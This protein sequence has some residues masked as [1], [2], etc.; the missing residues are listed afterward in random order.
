M[1]KRALALLAALPLAAGMA[2]AV[3]P[4]AHAATPVINGSVI[5]AGNGA[6]Y[7]LTNDQHTRY[8]DAQEVVKAVPGTGVVLGSVTLY[9]Q[10]STTSAQI[11]LVAVTPGVYAVK[12]GLGTAF[13]YD[14][15]VII[16]STPGNVLAGPPTIGT[17]DSVKIEL[18]YNRVT[19]QVSFGATDV[20]QSANFTTV[21][22]GTPG[23]QNFTEAGYGA[24][25][26]NSV[27]NA[28]ENFYTS[29][30]A[31]QS[32]AVVLGVFGVGGLTS[33]DQTTPALSPHGSLTAAGSF[34]LS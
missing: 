1:H 14:N 25:V 7:I 31:A 20:T 3:S 23:A 34:T 8:R 27:T 12:Y 5:D 32:I 17:G 18:F 4:A 29:T 24:G 15:N 11:E 26:A 22:V 28:L 6:G 21:K 16:P 9:D 10:A 2:L 13:V 30:H 19:Q 33:A